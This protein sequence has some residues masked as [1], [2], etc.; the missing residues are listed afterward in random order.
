VRAWEQRDVFEINPE[1]I[2]DPGQGFYSQYDLASIVEGTFPSYF[3]L[4]SVSDEVLKAVKNSKRGFRV[5][6]KPYKAKMPGA[7]GN[8]EGAG[9]GEGP[10]DTVPD[11][12]GGSGEQDVPGGGLQEE[13]AAAAASPEAADESS[14]SGD[15]EPA[16]EGGLVH[17]ED[18]ELTSKETAI[19]VIACEGFVANPKVIG[20]AQDTQ[21]AMLF[22]Y[23]SAVQFFANAVDY[24]SLGGGFGNIRARQ[25]LPRHIDS[26]LSEKPGTVFTLKLIG[27][28]GGAFLAVLLGVILVFL[29]KASRRKEV[30]L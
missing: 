22:G 25:I 13:P 20:L 14:G 6:S 1:K 12:A 9:E 7:E 19:V 4:R 5:T 17:P 29:R 18:I 26:E 24:L 16:A 2:V 21:S 30:V 15:G 23:Y 11:D 27:T 10:A 8:E 3:T 28:V